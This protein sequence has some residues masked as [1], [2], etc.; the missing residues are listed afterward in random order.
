M[1]ER[2]RVPHII[3][4]NKSGG[5]PQTWI[6]VDTETLPV[7]LNKT[8]WQHTFRLAVTATWKRERASKPETVAFQR[9]SDSSELVRFLADSPQTRERIGITAH[10][11][12]YDTQVLD[13]AGRLPK[14]DYQLTRAVIERGKWVQ[15]WTKGTRTNGSGSRTLLFVDLGNFF[16]VPLADIAVWLG[17]RKRPLPQF[18]ASDEVWFRHCENDVRIELAALQAWLKFCDENDLGYFA[19]TMAGQAFNA[20]RH[21]FMAHQIYVHVHSDVI[22]LERASYVGGRCQ[23]FFRGRAPLRPYAHVDCNS[24]Y[25]SVMYDEQFP[26][27]QVGHYGPVSVDRL[28]QILQTHAAVALVRINTDVPAFPLRTGIAV[29]FPIGT[30]ET[31]LASPELAL[32]IEYGYVSD[33][34]EVVTYDKA[35]IFRDYAEYFW[36]LRENARL[37]G[38]EF[39][40]KIGKRFLAALHGKFGQRIFTSLLVM[41][42]ADREDE[43]WTEYDIEDRAWYEYRSLAGRVEQ[44]VREVNGRDTLVAIPS[45]VA[46]YARVKLWRWIVTAGFDNVLY[47]DTDSLIVKWEALDRLREYV[48]PHTLG[49][50]RLLNQSRL[51]YIRAPKW[52]RFGNE[53]RRAGVS[54]K[55]VE[56]DWDQFEQD[57][58]RS[59]RWALSH[60][61]A[62]SAIVEEVKINAPYRKLLPKDS[63]G[64]W[65]PW[66]VAKEGAN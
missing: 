60:K 48:N 51:V 33:V 9:H 17:M 65:I 11:L 58:F 57:N 8:Q 39:I 4:G 12:D 6:V 56:V 40:S 16:P 54:G 64:H 30:F 35:P 23:P 50:L 13:V 46:S 5:G 49:G 44:R 53:Q 18:G 24:M 32:G 37:R 1:K 15:R 41:T 52:Y 3:R 31:V 34:R 59:S 10:N 36:N 25:G 62:H 43:I 28:A 19:P 47:V 38:D 2:D 22:G 61:Y 21:R 63:L 7:R 27:K 14:H 29:S 55:A 45:H 26:I 20:F 66:I 42:G